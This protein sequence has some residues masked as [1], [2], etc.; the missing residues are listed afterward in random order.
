[1]QSNASDDSGFGDMS[2]DSDTGDG[3]DVSGAGSSN[4]GGPGFN[5]GSSSDQLLSNILSVANQVVPIWTNTQLALQQQNQLSDPTYQGYDNGPT[6]QGAGSLLAGAQ[7]PG[8]A[9]ITSSSSML[10]I[11]A[12]VIFAVFFLAEK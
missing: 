3:S 6:T 2:G 1:M 10:L 11:A 12:V 4:S 8:G 9:L 5:Q 7:P